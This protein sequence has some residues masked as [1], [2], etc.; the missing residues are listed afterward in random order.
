MVRPKAAFTSKERIEGRFQILKGFVVLKEKQRESQRGRRMKRR[1]DT[2]ERHNKK[3]AKTETIASGVTNVDPTSD[4]APD[5]RK[6]IKAALRNACNPWCDW[7]ST[8][9]AAGCQASPPKEKTTTW[10]NWLKNN[11]DDL[12]KAIKE[13]DG[14][15]PG[16]KGTQ[17]KPLS[18]FKFAHYKDILPYTF[19]NYACKDKEKRQKVGMQVGQKAIVSFNTTALLADI[20]FCAE[21][22]ND[23]LTRQEPISTLQE[24][25]PNLTW[26]QAQQYSDRTFFNN[27]TGKV[28][29]R[30]VKAQ[31]T[32]T[33]C[34]EIMVSQQYWWF[35]KYQEGLN[36]FC[37]KNTGRC[38]KLGRHFGEVVQHFIIGGDEMCLMAD[39]GGYVKIVGDAQKRW[40]K[41]VFFFFSLA[42]MKSH[43]YLYSLFPKEAQQ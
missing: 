20:I 15:G 10:N 19:Q 24:L 26:I 2:E 13:W 37:E 16:A 12:E 38:R 29:K 27:N 23:G 21:R 3:R 18:L 14:I 35:K 43:I 39:A 25:E 9:D 5:T 36:F 1:S 7:V 22:D 33:K 17:G 41:R 28:N 30:L 8:H 34:I 11:T 31:Q 32:M 4:S 42:N 6:R 40:V